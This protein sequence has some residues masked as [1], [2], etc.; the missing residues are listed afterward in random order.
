MCEVS[1]SFSG[2]LV[3]HIEHIVFSKVIFIF[4]VGQRSQTDVNYSDLMQMGT[5]LSVLKKKVKMVNP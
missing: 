3:K 1:H 2:V 4:G 5:I